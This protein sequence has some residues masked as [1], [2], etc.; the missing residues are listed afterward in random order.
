YNMSRHFLRLLLVKGAV[1]GHA[2]RATEELHKLIDRR[3]KPTNYQGLIN[4][5]LM[6]T[7][8][9]QTINTIHPPPCGGTF[10]YQ[11]KAF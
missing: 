6:V 9:A 8:F 1:A 3:E 5:I 10:L 7:R 2:C 11:R 4:T